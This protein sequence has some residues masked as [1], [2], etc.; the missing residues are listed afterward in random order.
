MLA[1][2]NPP[3]SAVTPLKNPGILPLF[4]RV[5]SVPASVLIW[6]RD[7]DFKYFMITSA[8]SFDFLTSIFRKSKVSMDCPLL[9]E[10]GRERNFARRFITF[11]AAFV[12]TR[13]YSVAASTAL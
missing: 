10:R 8:V 12:V 6:M 3:P 11:L 4:I 7:E 13:L 5:R 9:V 1:E 2:E